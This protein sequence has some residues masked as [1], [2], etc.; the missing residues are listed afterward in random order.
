ME[1]PEQQ[2]STSKSEHNM[3]SYDF[4]RLDEIQNELERRAVECKLPPFDPQKLF[5]YFKILDVFYMNIEPLIDEDN[6]VIINKKFGKLRDDL[7]RGI[8][9]N[10]H[11]IKTSNDLINDLR[12]M[13]RALLKIKYEVGLG[14]PIIRRESQK[15]KIA[16][17]LGLET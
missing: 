15:I 11:V 3:G 2:K 5:A 13:H 14:I 7:F 16:R 12:N 1:K 6:K 17:A 4:I 8:E 10:R 9:A